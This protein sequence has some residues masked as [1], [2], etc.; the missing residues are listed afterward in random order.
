MRLNSTFR[1]MYLEGQKGIVA[2]PNDTKT[3]H[4]LMQETRY[5]CVSLLD[6]FHVVL[7]LNCACFSKFFLL[8]T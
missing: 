6:V 1:C 2:M 4:V 3:G 7:C 8:T 5:R